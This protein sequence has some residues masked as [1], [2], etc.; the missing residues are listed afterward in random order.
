MIRPVNR[1][2]RA[3]CDR[4]A[5]IIAERAGMPGDI[6]RGV[7]CMQAFPPFHMK[8]AYVQPPPVARAHAAMPMPPRSSPP[9]RLV[10]ERALLNPSHSIRLQDCVDRLLCRCWYAELASKRD[11]FAGKPVELEAV[12]RLKVIC[13]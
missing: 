1:R 7:I 11:H 9:D 2:F 10:G 6:L 5:V 13:H 8:S 3:A 4:L 12:T